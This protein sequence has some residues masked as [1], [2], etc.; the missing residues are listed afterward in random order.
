MGALS[1]G[2]F[3]GIFW[4]TASKYSGILVTLVVSA[5][6][7]RLLEP[8][9]FG[10]IALST[11][12]LQFFVLLAD[13][14][15]GAGIVQKYS[16]LSQRD[17]DVIF[18]YTILIG[19]CGCAVLLLSSHWLSS[20]YR[21]PELETVIDILSVQLF[22]V[23]VN[24]VPNAEFFV[25][26]RFREIGIRTLV[27]QIVTGVVSVI[28]A[29]K[30]L[31]IF[32][33]LITP[34]C[35]SIMIFCYDIYVYPRHI[36]MSLDIS[37]IRKIFNYSLFLVMFNVM[38]YLNRNIDKWI[39][40]K[41]LSME[42]LGYYS[43]SYRLMLMPIENITNVIT[44]VL[45]PMLK[46]FQNDCSIVAKYHNI[47]FKV[48]FCIGMPLGFFLFFTSSEIIRL[49]F[50][51]GWYPAAGAFSLFAITVPFQMIMSSSGVFYQISNSTKYL[52]YSGFIN[53]IISVSAFALCAV[54]HSSI[55]SFAI[56][57]GV[58]VLFQFVSNYTIVHLKVFK[59]SIVDYKNV[60]VTLLV[61]FPLLTI[62]Y[63]IINMLNV[64][65]LISFGLKSA[66]L[67][68]SYICIYLFDVELRQYVRQ[69]LNVR[70]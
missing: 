52:F 46:D 63:Y 13:A 27:I 5:I 11:V 25:N 38:N 29:Y 47:V 42:Q 48:L 55:E 31:G 35:T 8:E 60:I 6:L 7:A 24:M 32:S 56:A 53:S 14:G 49:F 19:L 44:P 39:V 70:K 36:V 3:R 40:G 50:G 23:S 10:L 66:V 2:I 54:S 67:V 68:I 28:A 64:N 65:W 69:L 41:C 12:V 33:L 61:A 17:L 20:V 30:G 59:L 34:V 26:K 62:A 58:S 45:H 21:E 37:C 57:W 16:Q 18:N 9:L 22:F 4:T 15:I 1:N 51:E 43:K